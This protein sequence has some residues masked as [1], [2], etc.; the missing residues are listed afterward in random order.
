MPA[1]AAEKLAGLRDRY[2]IVD[3]NAL[4]FFQVHSHLDLEHSRAEGEAI[5]RHTGSA[6]E[7]AVETALLAALDAWWN[8]LDGVNEL[9]LRSTTVAA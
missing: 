9:R 1:V 6:E 5:A 2:G 4:L 7:P 3:Q 8:F